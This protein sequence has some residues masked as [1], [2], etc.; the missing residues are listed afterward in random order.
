M[1]AP[2]S[3]SD[4]HGASA[5]KPLTAAPASTGAGS[6]TGQG[7]SAAHGARAGVGSA[8]T[9]THVNPFPQSAAVLQSLASARGAKVTR[10]ANAPTEKRTFV[11]DMRSPL[12]GEGWARR[13]R[14]VIPLEIA[15]SMP[16][17][18]RRVRA[19]ARRA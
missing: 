8:V 1:P 4:A 3:A 7:W 9:S 6:T 15:K 19:A 13:S 5:Q 14:R 17:R 16:T 10:A 11:R 18:D 12:L 2:Q